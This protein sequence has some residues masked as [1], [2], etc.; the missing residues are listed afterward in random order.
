MNKKQT[1][2]DKYFISDNPNL[3]ISKIKRNYSRMVE[4]NTIAPQ[5]LS[6][7]IVITSVSFIF[8]ILWL[9]NFW[10]RKD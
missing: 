7:T 2:F 3:K 9:I 1:T 6:G 10:H 4:P 8:L 5:R